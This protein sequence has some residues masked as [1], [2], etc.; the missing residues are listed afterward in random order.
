MIRTFSYTGITS[1]NDT[2]PGYFHAVKNLNALLNVGI[3][4]R[5]H[6]GEGAAYLNVSFDGQ[7]WFTV[8]DVPLLANQTQ[9]IPLAPGY[10]GVT[11]VSLAVPANQEY[12][13]TVCEFY[14]PT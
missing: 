6:T 13:M 11:A 2:T 14:F 8:L 7:N 12:A 10:Q 9:F 3:Q 4:C 5:D 1:E